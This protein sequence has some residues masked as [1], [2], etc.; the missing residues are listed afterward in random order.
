M[1]GVDKI[2]ELLKIILQDANDIFMLLDD[3]RNIIEVNEAAIKTYGYSREEFQKLKADDMRAPEYRVSLPEFFN[4]LKIEN[5]TFLN[6]YHIRKNGE[7]FPVEIGMAYVTFGSQRYIHSIIRETT[8]RVKFEKNLLKL[9]R[10]YAVLSNVNQLIVRVKDKQKVIEGACRIAVNDGQ[11][12]MVW[13]SLFEED[14]QKV[15]MFSIFGGDESFANFIQ[16]LLKDIKNYA[17]PS[18]LCFREKKY[19]ISYDFLTEFKE[20][21]EINVALQNKIYSVAS[22]PLLIG[23]RL[24]GI[25]T[26]YADDKDFF[27]DD[28]VKLLDEMASD[29]SFAIESIENDDRRHDVEEALKMSEERMRVVIEGTPNLFFYIQDIKADLIY[30]SPTVEIITGYSVEQ[31]LKRRDWFVTDSPINNYARQRTQAH[32]NGEYTNEV[33]ILEIY[34]KEGHKL[35]LEAYENPIY[36]DGKVAGLQGVAHDVTEKKYAEEALKESEQRFRSLYENSIIGFYRTTPDGKIL[37]ANPAILEMLGY[38]TFKE[39]ADRNLEDEGYEPT[40]ERSIFIEKIEKEGV[41]VGF[42]SVWIKKDGT[43]IYVRENAKAIRDESGKSLYYD[44]LVENITERRKAE[45]EIRKLYS[46]TE[47]SPVS[48]IITNIFGDIEYANPRFTEMTGYSLEEIKGQNP[49]ILQSGLKTKED[50]EKIWE[51]ILSGRKWYGEFYNKKKDGTFFWVSASISSIKN[52]E[53]KITNFIGVEE[54]ITDKKK[55]LEELVIAKEKAEEMNRLKTNF[56][57]NMS[58]ELRTPL[59]GILGFSDILFDEL[60]EPVYKD[61]VKSINNGGNRLLKTLNMVL[62]LSRIESS[63]FE[64]NP[65]ELELNA[66]LKEAVKLFDGAAQKK[67]LYLKVIENKNSILVKADEDLLIQVFNNLINNAIKFTNKGGIILKLDK[68]IIDGKSWAIIKVIDTG[69]GI[70]KQAL[71]IIFEEF[72]QVS[73]GLNRAFEGTGLGLTITKKSIELLDGKISVESAEGK[74]S[75]FSVL[76]PLITVN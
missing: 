12:R 21:A 59:I 32:L 56:L 41:V 7:I 53:G 3:E 33:V 9:N 50:Y 76:L 61:M 25:F 63:K 45:D 14:S 46:A 37:M 20:L 69:I 36:K 27:N 5:K 31:W 54:D 13:I 65:K 67:N 75:T 70:P 17:G 18:G 66:F 34:H 71:E 64:L 19:F 38:S 60:K 47:Q 62:D 8:D 58:H 22:F 23:N 2:R 15:K 24:A 16:D 26:L 42:E 52:K 6:T 29:I 57:A 44:G 11:Y 1:I 49:R 28:E 72:R 74:G 30:V 35:I 10:V 73:E 55:I 43:P 40:Y 48:V 4:K 68:E 39:L 51:K